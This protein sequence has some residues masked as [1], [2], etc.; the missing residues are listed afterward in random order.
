MQHPMARTRQNRNDRP[1]APALSGS[2]E[3]IVG[4][5]GTSPQEVPAVKAITGERAVAWSSVAHA[6][7]FRFFIDAVSEK[8]IEG[9]IL[10]IKQPSDRCVVV[11]REGGRVLARAIASRFR[12]DL[13]NAGIGDGHHSFVIPIP[14][15]LLDGEEHLLDIVEQESGVRLTRAPI[16]WRAERAVPRGAIGKAVDHENDPRTPEPPAAQATDFRFFIDAVSEKQIEGWILRI[17]QPSDRCVVVLKEGDRI[18]ARAIASRFRADLTKTGIG[19]GQHSF[20][21]PTPSG[22]LDGEEHLLDIVEQ[23]SGIRLTQGP[24]R[25]RAERAAAHQVIDGIGAE[26]GRQASPEALSG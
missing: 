10:R 5:S 23:E 3:A 13:A 17:K 4:I 7:D 16:P 2:D 15:G 25:W 21:I 22:L 24:I 1:K 12:A 26:L 11:L 20:V 9:W 14:S 19:D 18:L 6:T 8:Q